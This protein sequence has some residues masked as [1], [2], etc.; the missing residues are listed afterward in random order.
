MR[1]AATYD[2]IHAAGA[3]LL[4]VSVDDETR[5]AGMAQRWALH[6]TTMV[7]DPG[8]T[9]IL[10]P[11]DLFDPAERGGIALPGMVVFDPSGTE[12]YRYCGRDFADRTNDEDLFA[13]LDA[14]NLPPST[15]R[16]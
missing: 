3:E 13:A 10:Q 14:L 4:A 1:L 11:L 15:P 12:V 8:G 7:A 9:D 16:P 5:Q 2:R 6:H